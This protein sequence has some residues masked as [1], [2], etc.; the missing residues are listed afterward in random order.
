MNN[1]K[2]K[3]LSSIQ[4]MPTG[5]PTK[6]SPT[7]ITKLAKLNP[8]S[9]STSLASSALSQT[10]MQ[11]PAAVMINYLLYTMYS[12]VGSIIYYP[13]FLANL[14][15]SNLEESLPK[16]DLCMKMGL[17]ERVCKKK[18]KC[19]FKSCH[20][21]DDPVGYKLD[22]Q[23][24][25]PCNRK[26]REQQQQITKKEIMI[27]G[28]GRKKRTRKFFK[29][30]GWRKF[31]SHKMI[32]KMKKRYEQ[33]ILNDFFGKHKRNKTHKKKYVGGNKKLDKSCKNK[34]NKTLCSIIDKLVYQ[35]EHDKLKK[36]LKIKKK[37]IFPQFGGGNE[38]KIKEYISSL[39]K[40]N[41][42]EL[43]KIIEQS[44]DKLSNIIN[45]I[46][47][48]FPSV[49]KSA[50]MFP[51]AIKKFSGVLTPYIKKF[52]ISKISDQMTNLKN[53]VFKSNSK[54]DNDTKERKNLIRSFFVEQI[55]SDSLFKLA[56]IIK[57]MEKLFEDEPLS[58]AEK[59]EKGNQE[60]NNDISI[61]FPW[62][63]NNPTLDLK[64]KIK[65]LSSHISQTEFERQK[66][67]ELYDKCFVCKHCTLR[68]TA[69]AV[70]GNVIKG[71]LSGNKSK[72]FTEIINNTF[73]LLRKHIDFSFMTEKQY[74]L[75]TLISLHLANENLDIGKVD[76]SFQMYGSSYNLK[77]LI[78]GIPSVSFIDKSSLRNHMVELRNTYASYY[79]IGIVED[80]HG[81][82]YE[83]ILKRYFEMEYN[84]RA[85]RLDFLKNI[86][87]K[88]YNILYT[89]HNDDVDKN[90][91]M[92][93]KIYDNKI[94][95]DEM[96]YF[97][98]F[99]TNQ[100]LNNLKNSSNYSE[101]NEQLT[102]VLYP[103]YKF[104]LKESNF[105]YD[106]LVMY[107]RRDYDRRDYN[108][109]DYDRRDYDRRD[110][111]RRDY[112]R[113]DYNRLDYDNDNQLDEYEIDK[114]LTNIT[115][116]LF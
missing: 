72:Q 64:D 5:L 10:G 16:H 75:T 58:S 34:H 107:N 85:E 99:D 90:E 18:I 3:A 112:N 7:D 111:D 56:I 12:L 81:I 53:K 91:G 77:D 29:K 45:E 23:V 22:K 52:D 9:L 1:I 100:T 30:N 74:Y 84:D 88:N 65:C 104:L 63:F 83:S 60:K 31:L 54:D 24:K 41:N 51:D 66:N 21:L 40:D 38:N 114:L 44:P 47:E 67:P 43:Y 2:N 50:M 101:L 25:K 89:E 82:Y 4:T 6:I 13:A 11:S 69:S 27:G 68:N 48:K 105:D 97:S 109:R 17:S 37:Y 62:N 103:Q 87:L 26:R 78:V 98:H 79:Q 14:P 32:N 94:N 73:G 35:E 55:K 113:R 108:R 96:S 102:F 61:V 86:A 19:F 116:K 49:A 110:Y 42:K 46:K 36:L 15:E 39:I 80:I 71:I 8:A 20:Y 70:W 93:E 28:A 59:K 76:S 33:N 92:Y 95:S 106:S 115:M 57:I